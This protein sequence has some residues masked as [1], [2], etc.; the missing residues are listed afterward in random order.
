MHNESGR[1]VY[2]TTGVIAS[3]LKGAGHANN[4]IIKVTDNNRVPYDNKVCYATRQGEVPNTAVETTSTWSDRI[5]PDMSAKCHGKLSLHGQPEPLN[6]ETCVA[7]N[8]KQKKIQP[9]SDLVIVEIYH[10]P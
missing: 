7:L 10:N 5:S 6:G 3:P 2:S 1:N 8:S 9:E 4:V